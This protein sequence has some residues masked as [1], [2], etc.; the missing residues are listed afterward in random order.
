MNIKKFQLRDFLHAE[1]CSGDSM[2]I[3]DS[4]HE[5]AFKLGIPLFDLFYISQSFA[6]LSLTGYAQFIIVLF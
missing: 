6:R 4:P 2:K 1:L 3:S 5:K